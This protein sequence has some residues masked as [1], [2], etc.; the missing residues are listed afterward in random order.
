[1]LNNMAVNDR[2]NATAIKMVAEVYKKTNEIVKF[3]NEFIAGAEK[4]I[5]EFKTADQKEDEVFKTAMRQG[6]REFKEVILLDIEKIYHRISELEKGGA[7]IDYTARIAYINLL[8]ANWVGEGTTYSQVVDIEGITANS[9]VDLTP[10]VEQLVIFY[11]KDL[12]FVTENENGVVTVYVIGQKPAN[13]Y[14]IQA[15]I[16]EVDA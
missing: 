3:V 6:F 14:T 4:Q 9:Q 13:D 15:T 2:E 8:S 12:T 5:N 1:M 10:S 7:V 11:E 16:T